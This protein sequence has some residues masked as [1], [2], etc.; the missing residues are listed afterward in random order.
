MEVQGHIK[1]TVIERSSDEVI[2]EM[3]IQPGILNPFGTVNAGATLWLADVNASVLVL[4]GVDP[5]KG[6]KGFPLAININANLL[7]NNTT[8]AFV[9]K[10]NYVKKGRTVSVVKTT[11]TDTSGKLIAEV[12]T[13][14]VQST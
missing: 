1:F 6:M 7:G 12:T 13:S 10:S 3:P 14:H 11:V 4:A 2:S 8:G 5:E 9:A